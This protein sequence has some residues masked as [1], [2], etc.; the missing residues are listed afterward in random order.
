MWAVKENKAKLPIVC[1]ICIKKL[2]LPQTKQRPSMFKACFWPQILLKNKFWNLGEKTIPKQPYASSFKNQ[3]KF[4]FILQAL[5]W[6]HA[7]EPQ[8]VHILHV[9]VYFWPFLNT[10]LI[11][12]AG[13]LD[14]QNTL[15]TL[16]L[17]DTS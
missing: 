1:F 8:I 3:N 9:L 17:D 16:S 4:S 2:S 12:K 14:E 6:Q 7:E 11:L 13:P 15:H 5:P 10:F